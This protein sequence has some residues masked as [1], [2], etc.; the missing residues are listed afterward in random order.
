LIAIICDEIF[1]FFMLKDNR[2]FSMALVS[3]RGIGTPRVGVSV[4]KPR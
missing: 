1:V 2:K 3:E 4:I